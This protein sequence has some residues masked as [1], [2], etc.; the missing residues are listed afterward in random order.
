MPQRAI[1][2]SMARAK[3]LM[4]GRGKRGNIVG[5]AFV[6]LGGMLPFMLI[7]GHKGKLASARHWF[8]WFA[9]LA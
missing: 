6:L 9:I 7:L 4:G 1:F 3:G 5:M 2:V 8:P